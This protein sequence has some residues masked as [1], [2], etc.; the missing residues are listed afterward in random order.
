MVGLV[1]QKLP[2]NNEKSGELGPLLFVDLRFKCWFPEGYL[3]PEDAIL[4]PRGLELPSLHWFGEKLLGLRDGRSGGP[5]FQIVLEQPFLDVH[6]CL[7]WQRALQKS[8]QLAAIHVT[9]A[10]ATAT[11]RIISQSI[12]FPFR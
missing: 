4:I 9:E 8:T 1:L 11:N 12:P 5:E 6:S 10:T 2:V 7:L 3:L